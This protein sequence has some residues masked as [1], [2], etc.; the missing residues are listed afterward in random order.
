LRRINVRQFEQRPRWFGHLFPQLLFALQV[1]QVRKFP[2]LEIENLADFFVNIGPPLRGRCFLP[3]Q[4][5]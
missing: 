3:G 4:Q 5:L 1:R 2:A